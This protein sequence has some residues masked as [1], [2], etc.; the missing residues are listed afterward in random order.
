MKGLGSMNLNFRL[1]LVW[2]FLSGAHVG[3]A[4]PLK[5]FILAGQSN[6]QGHAKVETFDY[7]GED[8][9]TSPLLA[10]MRAPDGSPRVADNAWI[11]YLT[12]GRGTGD[13][14]GFGKLTAGYGAR[15]NPAKPKRFLAPMMAPIRP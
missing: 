15:T 2:V 14:E 7:I 9:K 6:M 12:S 1:A 10:L 5:I 3:W 11:S 4:E 8:P 13:G